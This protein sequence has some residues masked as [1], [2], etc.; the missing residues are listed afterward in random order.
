MPS[1]AVLFHTE[2]AAMEERNRFCLGG[3][4]AETYAVSV[5]V[6]VHPGRWS[7]E[8]LARFLKRHR[9]FCSGRPRRER[10]ILLEILPDTLRKVKP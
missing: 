4:V 2:V 8:E 5:L 1:E 10:G 9:E 6:T 3:D 7:D